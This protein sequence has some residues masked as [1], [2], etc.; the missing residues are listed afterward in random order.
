MKHS[1]PAMSSFGVVSWE[2]LFA[3]MHRDKAQ[4]LSGGTWDLGED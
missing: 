3:V 2:H 1:M 4:R